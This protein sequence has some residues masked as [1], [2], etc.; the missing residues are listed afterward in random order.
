MDSAIDGNNTRL[1][2]REAVEGIADQS[3]ILYHTPVAEY[4]RSSRWPEV[5]GIDKEFTEHEV[6]KM[7]QQTWSSRQLQFSEAVDKK[8][9]EKSWEVLSKRRRSLAASC[10][11]DNDNDDDTQKSPNICR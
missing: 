4:D 7:W 3:C 9:V 2:H 1:D 10:D 6:L 11:N 5:K 8:D